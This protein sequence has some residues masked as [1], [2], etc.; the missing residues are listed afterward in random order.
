MK[1]VVKHDA[2]AFKVMWTISKSTVTCDK[3]DFW[4]I[5]KLYRKTLL[6]KPFFIE[7]VLAM[8]WSCLILLKLSKA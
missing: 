8:W 2:H 1:I 7:N 5:I 3:D 4:V 6:N